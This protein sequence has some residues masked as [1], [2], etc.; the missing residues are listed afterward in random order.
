[1]VLANKIS[2]LVM[3]TIVLSVS[4]MIWLASSDISAI[5]GGTSILVSEHDL[6]E[7]YRVR[8]HE[9]TNTF[10]FSAY[11][12]CSEKYE[13]CFDIWGGGKYN[14]KFNEVTAYGTYERYKEK[15]A[16]VFESGW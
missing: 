4:S 6:N 7:R 15:S 2:F 12:V 8:W 3:I 11:D 13:Q 5:L 9:P 1:M 16:I 10:V 14:F